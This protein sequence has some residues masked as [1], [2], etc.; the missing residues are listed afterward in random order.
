MYRFFHAPSGVYENNKNNK[1]RSS[2]IQAQ[3]WE[4][5]EQMWKDPEK[6]TIDPYIL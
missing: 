6:L 3:C 5:A 4:V 2:C 1:S